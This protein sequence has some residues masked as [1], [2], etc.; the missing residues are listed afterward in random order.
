MEQ[1]R[2]RVEE[3][4]QDKATA[5]ALKPYYNTLC[6]RA[7]F[8]DAYLQTFNLPSVTLVDTA[9]RGVERITENAVVVDGKAYEIDCLIYATG[10]DFYASD[11]AVRNGFEIYGRGGRSL[12][13]KWRPGVSTLHG[14]GARDFPNCV[15]QTNAQGSMTPNITHT[16][17]AGARHFVYLVKTARERAIRTFEPSEAAE[18]AWV[19]RIRSRAY[20]TKF[21][22]ECTP[23]YYN[24]EGKPTA[25]IG[26][27][28]FYPGSPV[29]FQAMMDDWRARGELAGMD[30][31]GAD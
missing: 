5:E 29:R 16:L 8:H 22:L 28:A 3:I 9:G 4:V 10:F 6:K 15:F 21:D 17:E 23:G 7:C 19:E 2:H 11:L 27:N 30:V 31:S 25:D 24:N 26:I 12:T 1:V 18:R 14:F 20:R 13:E